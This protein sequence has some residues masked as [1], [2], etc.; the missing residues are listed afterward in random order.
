MIIR[1]DQL[2]KLDR[3]TVILLMADAIARVKTNA[4]DSHYINQQ[5]DLVL[6]CLE[7]LK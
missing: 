5:M 7:V 6:S 4:E 2:A 1:A 3:E